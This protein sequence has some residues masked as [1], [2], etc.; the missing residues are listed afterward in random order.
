MGQAIS[1]FYIRVRVGSIPAGISKNVGTLDLP[2]HRY[3]GTSRKSKKCG[4]EKSTKRR[5]FAELKYESMLDLLED[6]RPGQAKPPVESDVAPA[7][8]FSENI[9]R[10]WIG[11]GVPNGNAFPEIQNVPTTTRAFTVWLENLAMLF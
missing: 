9:R 5:R 8:L 7:N 3:P 2:T 11:Q 1:R 10:S 6:T 4:G